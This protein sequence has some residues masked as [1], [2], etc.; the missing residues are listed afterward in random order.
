MTTSAEPRFVP[1]SQDDFLRDIATLG[2][3]I[4]ADPG[5]SPDFLIGIGRGG[6][7]PATYLSH[8]MG[9]ALLS[10]DYSSKVAGFAEDLLA[11]LAKRV[12]GGEHIL[13]IDDIN[14]SGAT[15][16]FLRHRLMDQGAV[17]ERL[18]FGVLIDNSRSREQ[19]DYRARTIDR[20]TDK[21]WFVFP[22]EGVAPRGALIEDAR[23][24]P[25]R[26]A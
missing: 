6:L 21:S 3:A 16:A 24:V 12:A 23:A 7:V 18:R 10:V 9:I 14:D 25:E 26:L 2:E 13:L 17:A 22:W 15:I 5:W 20:A 11:Q 8:R 4:A 1:I 19:V